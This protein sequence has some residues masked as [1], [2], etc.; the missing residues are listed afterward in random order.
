[1]EQIKSCVYA[2]SRGL[3][4]DWKHYKH[5][6]PE[7]VYDVYMQYWGDVILKTSTQSSNI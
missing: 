4:F 5:P 3:W 1:M 6:L 7:H 2:Y